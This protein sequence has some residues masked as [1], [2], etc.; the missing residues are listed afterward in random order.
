MAKRVQEVALGTRTARLKL[1]GRHKP[2]FRAITEG[3]HLGYRRSTVSGKAGSWL[4]RRHLGGTR[5]AVHLLGAADDQPEK[6]C[7][8]NGETVLTFDQAQAAAREWARVQAAGERNA[9]AAAAVI[10]VSIAVKAYIASRK[11]RAEA[12]GR[13]AEL[14]LNHHVLA[15]PL[16]DVALLSLTDEDLAR[17]RTGLARGGRG[18]PGKRSAAPL[19]PATLARLLNDLRAALT[20]TARKDRVPA[21]V[22]TVIKEGLRAPET[23]DRARPKQV[24]TDADVRRLAAAAA[25]HDPDFGA[26]VLFLATTGARF[27]QAARVTVADLQ[28]DARR[29]MVPASAKGRGTKQISHIP[30]PLP[31]DAIGVLQ[32]LAAG[33]AGHEPLLTR[34][35]HR[36]VAGDRVAGKL[37]NWER[38]GRRPW[39]S[40]AQMA[41][42]WRAILAATGLPDALVPYCLRHSSIVRGLRAG[43]PVSLVAKVH[44]TSA[45]MIG[46]HYGAFIV[47]ATE[48]LL[49]RAVVP[50]APTQPAR[51]RAVP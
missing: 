3:V 5:Y 33:R 29:V 20:A 30:V 6:E 38:D 14:R 40:A 12:A 10:T 23:P 26:L 2:Y 44:D 34:W 47:D 37:P 51:L 16:A 4:C 45:N 46:A 41:R 24:V 27:D 42:Q 43:L 7:P 11:A 9:K 8:A 25:D 35:H 1:V 31:D 13:D 39:T 17:W 36:Q 50:M 28:A 48:D 32:Q 21:E 18:A 19:A 22:H 15:A 49:R